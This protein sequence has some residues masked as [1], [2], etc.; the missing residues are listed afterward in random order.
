[1]NMLEL[2]G[3]LYLFSSIVM[4]KIFFLLYEKSL[5]FH[6][7]FHNLSGSWH[8]GISAALIP[9]LVLRFMRYVVHL[10]HTLLYIILSI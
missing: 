2:E 1:M 5:L 8:G 6:C 3:Y 10:Q 7:L 4:T 9:V